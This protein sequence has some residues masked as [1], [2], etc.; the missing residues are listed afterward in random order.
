M[1]KII[2]LAATI[3]SIGSANAQNIA[4]DYLDINNVK[5]RVSAIGA[6]V[7]DGN[8]QMEVPIGNG[9][10]SIY[11]SG[12][13]IGGYDT[14]G[15]LRLAGQTY[16]QN[17]TDFFPGP[18]N[19]YAT[20]DSAA[21]VIYNKVWKISKCEIDSFIVHCQTGLPA[22]YVVPQSIMDWPAFHPLATYTAPYFDSVAP[23][24]DANGNGGYDPVSGCDYPLI[25]G[26]QAILF[27]YNDKGGLHTETGGADIGLQIRGM[28]YAYACVDDSA[29]NNTIFTNYKIVN[30]G[31]YRVDS[32]FIGNW[33]D[34]DIGAYNDD[35][36]ACD[37]TR[38]AYYGYNGDQ[39]DGPAVAGEQ[40]YGAN[41]PAQ[42]VVFL[43]GPLA[44]PDNTDNAASSVPASFF[45][46]GDGTSDNE[47]LGMSRFTY[48]NNDMNIVDGNPN[49]ADDYYQFMSGTWKNGT[50]ITYGADGK[51]GTIPCHYMFPG[52]SDP[53]GFGTNGVIQAP[54]DEFSV[55]KNPSDKRGL[56]S[57]GPFTLQP[58]AI[59]E[60]DF[61]YVF[62]RATSG[63]NMASVGVMN[64]YIDSVRAKFTAGIKGCSC[65]NI[66]AGIT[67]YNNDIEFSIYPN[68]AN[69][70]ITIDY[71]TASKNYSVKIY[72]ATGKIVKSI[73]RTNAK[74]N[75]SISDL[76][77]GIYLMNVND[78][79][80]SAVH[81]FVKQ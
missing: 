65:D 2:L 67:D 51:S 73:E 19:N 71:G 58:G 39:I 15:A 37:V 81:R 50:S 59:Q 55:G 26:D 30:K 12:L 21:C 31:S 25:K 44:D 10:Y 80:N 54:W 57:Y 78:G 56:G 17:G 46:Y 52:N 35:Y 3:M 79:Q 60:I 36:V 40:V 16:R 74:T 9:T 77:N 41:P 1:K 27:F 13:W 34:F 5:A 76:N 11:G 43:R 42:A 47:R 22:N 18:L 28:A 7:A 8:P 48:Y 53:L 20:T 49:G 75:I 70:N 14:G 6:L 29:L 72:D 66:S 23:Y 24:F 45:G 4:N 61:A 63:G 62:G 32:V 68:P 33:T 64:N 69:D 38:G